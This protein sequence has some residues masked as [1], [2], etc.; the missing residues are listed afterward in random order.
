MWLKY[1]GANQKEVLTREAKKRKVGL[2]NHLP[3]VELITGGGEIIGAI[4][5]DLRKEKPVLQII[6]AKSVI[7][8]YGGGHQTLPVDHAGEAVQYVLLPG[9][10]GAAGLAY[11]SG[12]K[13]VNMEF[14]TATQARS[15]SPAP[16]RRPGSGL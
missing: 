12:A 6:R 15:T 2:L 11:R 3:I 16:G 14:A 8:C 13:L 9:G 7:L 1:A 4:G 10:T 5:L